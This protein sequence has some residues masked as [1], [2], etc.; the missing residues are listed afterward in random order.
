MFMLKLKTYE[1][2]KQE[3]TDRIIKRQSRGSVPA[4]NGWWMSR[5]EL[6]VRSLR[7]DKS[8]RYLERAYR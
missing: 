3:A 8:M 5:K 1:Q 2:E 6:D 4:Q 7:A